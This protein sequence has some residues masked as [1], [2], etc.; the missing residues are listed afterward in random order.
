[1]PSGKAPD[2]GSGDRRF[3]NR[4]DLSREDRRRRWRANQRVSGWFRDQR[5]ALRRTR[6]PAGDHE[7][8]GG[9]RADGDGGRHLAH[10]RLRN[11]GASP[12]DPSPRQSW[13]PSAM[14]MSIRMHHDWP[15]Y[16]CQDPQPPRSSWPT[17]V[18]TPRP[19]SLPCCGCWTGSHPPASQPVRCWRPMTGSH[20]E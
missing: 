17:P 7:H 14:R 6:S 20:H 19:S 5:P 12:R 4:Q 18:S 1:M 10:G 9:C 8:R 13:R 3:R 15:Y 16:T 2:S 11:R